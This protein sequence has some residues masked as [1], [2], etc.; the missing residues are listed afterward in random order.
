MP[1]VQEQAGEDFV[2]QWSQLAREI[3]ACLVGVGQGFAALQLLAQ[4][5]RAEFQRRDQRA[6]PGGTQATQL[7]E[8]AAGPVQ[9]ATP[10]DARAR[11]KGTAIPAG[12]SASTAKPKP[13]TGTP[14]TSPAKPIP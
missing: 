6:G 10:F 7:G 1:R 8:F 5:P 4:V 12:P 3:G 14:T 2:G 9:Q 11:V 13:A